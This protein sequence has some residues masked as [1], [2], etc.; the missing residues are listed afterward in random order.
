VADW[1]ARIRVPQGRLELSTGNL[2]CLESRC[3]KNKQNTRYC[4]FLLTSTTDSGIFSSAALKH[5]GSIS[6][7]MQPQMA[8]ERRELAVN[9]HSPLPAL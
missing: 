3:Q 5:L 9:F 6:C 1:A 7:V 2:L 8:A 4:G